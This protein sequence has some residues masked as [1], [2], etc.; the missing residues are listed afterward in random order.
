ML[1]Y[2]QVGPLP[3][4]AS[5]SS[6]TQVPFRSGNL[7]DLI[8][9]A[10]HGRYTETNY[11]RSLFIAT[12]NNSIATNT[13]AGVATTYSGL[14][15][16]NPIGTPINIVLNKVGFSF[17]NQWGSAASIGL[18]TGYNSG[19]NVTHSANAYVKSAFTGIGA[20]PQG[21]ADWSAVLPTAPTVSHIFGTGLTGTTAVIPEM[22][23]QMIDLE[24]SVIL[25]PGAYAAIFTSVASPAYSGFFSFS[26]E[27]VP[28]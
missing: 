5:I 12:S 22:G 16:S 25:P 24:G 11:R 21:L 17:A 18:M 28:V 23:A 7:G 8:V 9:S 4:T 15:L 20:A 13:T 19:T 3:V 10:L 2:T 1:I 14:C 26:W 27:E 6:G